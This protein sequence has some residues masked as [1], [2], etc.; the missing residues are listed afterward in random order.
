M[1]KR[2]QINNFRCFQNFVIELHDRPSVLIIGKNGSGKST[3]RE[4]LGILQKLAQGFRADKV[5]SESDFFQN[6]TQYPIQFI[7]DLDF[8]GKS[9]RYTIAIV[10]STKED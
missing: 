5:I 4:A 1:I 6:R 9:F 7:V 8:P 3:L 10:Q 2:L